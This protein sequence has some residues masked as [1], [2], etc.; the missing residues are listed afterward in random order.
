MVTVALPT[1]WSGSSPLWRCGSWVPPL[2]RSVHDFPAPSSKRWWRWLI[3]WSSSASI[4]TCYP[5]GSACRSATTPRPAGPIELADAV[6]PAW[7]APTSGGS[8]GRPKL[9]VSGDPGLIDPSV[10]AALLFSKDG[11]SSMP[12]PLYHNGPIVWASFAL[13]HGSHVVLLPGSMPKRRWRDGPTRGRRGVPGPHHD[14]A[15][16]ESPSRSAHGI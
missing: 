10:D 15:H 12:G 8:T 3:R 11:A 1:A 2:N 9:I 13:L 7:K 5:A 16:L 4:Q 14:E 6:S